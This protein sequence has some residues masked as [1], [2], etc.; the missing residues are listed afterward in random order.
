[1]TFDKNTWSSI[2]HEY[3]IFKYIDI[4]LQAFLEEMSI[5]K[6]EIFLLH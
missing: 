1:M 6:C 3:S 5:L 2:Y 4:Y